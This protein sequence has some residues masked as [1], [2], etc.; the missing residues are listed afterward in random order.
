VARGV[1][2]KITANYS[3]AVSLKTTAG[4]PGSLEPQP[5]CS[6]IKFNQLRPLVW[7]ISV[8]I[9]EKEHTTLLKDCGYNACLFKTK[10]SKSSKSTSKGSKDNKSPKAK[11]SGKGSYDNK[12]PKV[13]TDKGSK[14]KKKSKLRKKT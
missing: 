6:A 8:P 3:C 14:D 7:D 10:S 1:S 11:S 2:G 5:Q 13:K 12:S 9:T 4:Q